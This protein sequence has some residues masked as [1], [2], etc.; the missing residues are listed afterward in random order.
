VKEFVDHLAA[1]KALC[2][3]GLGALGF[4][5]GLEFDEARVLAQARAEESLEIR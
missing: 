5:D 1:P 4:L 2:N 3:Q